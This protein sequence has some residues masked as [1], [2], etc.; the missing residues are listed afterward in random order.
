[1]SDARGAHAIAALPPACF[2]VVTLVGVAVLQGWRDFSTSLQEAGWVGPVTI[3]MALMGAAVA[4]AAVGFGLPRALALAGACAPWLVASLGGLWAMSR[5]ADVLG[6][7]TIDPIQ[8][9]ALLTAGYSE[10]VAA[11]TIGAPVAVAIFAGVVVSALMRATQRR[12]EAAAMRVLAAFAVTGAGLALASTLAA[13]A[14]HG[15]LAAIARID[16]LSRADQAAIAAAMLED[17][18][19]GRLVGLVVAALGAIA[20]AVAVAMGSASA[21]AGRV[22]GAGV[23]AC[24]AVLVVAP[25]IDVLHELDALLEAGALRVTTAGRS[26]VPWDPRARDLRD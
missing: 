19:R 13:S 3:L 23:I 21:G 5:V 2:A 12:E 1:M 22:G 10:S 14:M 11:R 9:A 25:A 15:G 17:A 4:S 18:E 6:G 8:R 7:A 26:T 24:T 16:A 20:L